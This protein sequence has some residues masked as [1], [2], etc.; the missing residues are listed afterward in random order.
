MHLMR[1]L[2]ASFLFLP[3]LAGSGGCKGE[4]QPPAGEMDMAAPSTP[5]MTEPAPDM[6]DVGLAWR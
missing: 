4:M 6:L 2:G 5:D 1:Y 3:L